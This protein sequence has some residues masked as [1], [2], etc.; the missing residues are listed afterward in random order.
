MIQWPDVHQ[1][2]AVDLYGRRG[3]PTRR[4]IVTIEFVAAALGCIA[5]GVYLVATRSR[6]LS[7][8]GAA[9]FGLG[10]NYLPLVQHAV[11]LRGDRLALAAV[12]YDNPAARR[13]A[14]IAQLWLLV[15]Y[16]LVV[17]DL[18]QQHRDRGH[19]R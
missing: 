13:A 3:S 8:P 10:A 11:R 17:V 19:D 2:A 18:Y 16:A 5:L 15:P 7:V 14:A 12:G 1:L 9:V 4:V 6:A